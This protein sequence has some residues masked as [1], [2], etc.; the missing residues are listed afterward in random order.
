MTTHKGADEAWLRAEESVAFGLSKNSTVDQLIDQIKDKKIVMLGESTHG[1]S[2]YYLLRSEISKRLL[3]DEGFDFIGIE[4]DW[5]SCEGVNRFIRKES[6]TR[7]PREVLK[8]NFQRWPTWMW[9]N[10][11]IVPL[12][13]W[14][15]QQAGRGDQKKYFYGLDVYSLYESMT[16]VIRYVQKN[17]NPFL[18]KRIEQ[19][20]ACFAPFLRDEIE[21]AKSLIHY[22]E[23]C[24]AQ[25]SQSLKEL[26]EVRLEENGRKKTAL[27][28]AQQNARVVRNAESYYRAM[29]GGGAESWNL[30]DVHMLETLENLLQ[31]YG[32]DSKAIVWAHNTH[33]GDHRATDM[34]AAGYVNIG[35]L[36]RERFGAEN[37]ALVGF[38]S[39]EGSVRAA[40]AWGRND[41]R[42]SLPPAKNGSYEELFHKLCHMKREK[43]FYLD[44]T[45]TPLQEALREVKG[46]RAVGVVYDPRHEKRGNYV[47]TSLSA[48]YDAFLFIDQTNALHPLPAHFEYGEIPDTWPVGQ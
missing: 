21:Y 35:G 4:G 27:F 45:L 40:Y 29:I 22:P 34:A 2:E 24:E 6:E 19:N 33:I 16:E 32:E 46:H 18:A 47:P 13:E 12:I 11:E 9:A 15:A 26:L 7:N 28:G 48:R 23:G 36:A 31:H 42:M 37:V 25:V 17:V 39:Y 30:R 41:E 43:S 3:Q 5:P 1:T 14:L 44:L 8:S 38:G 20:Y 10:E